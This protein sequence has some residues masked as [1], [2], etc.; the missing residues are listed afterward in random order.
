[1]WEEDASGV[2]GV[3]SKGAKQSLPLLLV[4]QLYIG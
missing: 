2:R 3:E 4:I 1:M